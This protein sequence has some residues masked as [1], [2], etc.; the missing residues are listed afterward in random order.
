MNS[1]GAIFVALVINSV[2]FTTN[3]LGAEIHIV[4]DSPTQ[5]MISGED[6]SGNTN[7]E[8]RFAEYEN[9]NYGA[10]LYY[11][12]NNNLFQIRTGNSRFLPR[13]TFERTTG[14]IGVGTARVLST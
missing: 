12:D 5:M 14:N 8:L 9:G 2:F 11:D 13:M 4:E 10:S 3:V 1:L 6:N 7:M